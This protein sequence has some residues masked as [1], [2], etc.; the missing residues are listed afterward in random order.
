M[1]FQLSSSP[2]A[3]D[4][5]GTF[6]R[7]PRPHDFPA[8]GCVDMEV[9]NGTFDAAALAVSNGEIATLFQEP[10]SEIASSDGLAEGDIDLTF[11]VTGDNIDDISTGSPDLDGDGVADLVFASS[12]TAHAWWVS[13]D[14][15]ESAGESLSL[16]DEDELLDGAVE[17]IV[18]VFGVGD[19]TGDG[20]DEVLVD[21]GE[22]LVLVG[23]SDGA[24]ASAAPEVLLELEG[25]GYV[26]VS[27][28]GDLDGDARAD[29][30]IGAPGAEDGDGAAFVLL[31]GDLPTSGGEELEDVAWVSFYRAGG[32]ALGA[33]VAAPGDLDGD[34]LNDLLVG[35]PNATFESDGDGGVYR[36]SV[37]GW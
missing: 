7:C 24:S 18:Q 19:V 5:L 36:L 6:Y 25:L 27:A 8:Y 13:G 12:D 14:D 37:Q 1:V 28:A 3:V 31:G 35:A 26:Q 4:E 30:L 34:G 21:S 20:A 2:G 15:L 9:F 29:M 10:L 17:D 11:T 23:R 22:A 32:D 33:S 16:D